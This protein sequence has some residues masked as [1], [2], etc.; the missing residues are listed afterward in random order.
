MEAIRG[1]PPWQAPPRA[2]IRLPQQRRG[3]L[4]PGAHRQRRRRLSA[5]NQMP[6]RPGSR[7]EDPRRRP[8]QH[9]RNCSGSASACSGSSNQITRRAKCSSSGVGGRAFM[10]CARRHQRAADTASAP[11]DEPDRRPQRPPATAPLSRPAAQAC[12]RPAARPD[13]PVPPDPAGNLQAL[14]I[15][16]ACLDASFPAFQSSNI[17]C[18]YGKIGADDPRGFGSR[19]HPGCLA[20][21]H[22]ADAAAEG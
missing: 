2:W 16:P 14:P 9:A 18:Y 22:H 6:V 13:E 21:R 19:Q 5:A 10:V 15:F 11:A 1:R 17:A 4:Q 8:L 3:R 20:P 7:V 12:R